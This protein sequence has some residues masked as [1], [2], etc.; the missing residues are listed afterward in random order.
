MRH[1]GSVRGHPGLE[2]LP[3]S[4]FDKGMVGIVKE[5]LRSMAGSWIGLFRKLTGRMNE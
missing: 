5:L 3:L 1:Q 2:T 4:A